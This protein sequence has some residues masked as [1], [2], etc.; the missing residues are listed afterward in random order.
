MPKTRKYLPRQQQQQQ[1]LSY[2]SSSTITDTRFSSLETIAINTTLIF[3]HLGEY[4]NAYEVV[5]KF[6]LLEDEG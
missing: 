6:G 4:E 2:L 5:S 3:S 1:Q